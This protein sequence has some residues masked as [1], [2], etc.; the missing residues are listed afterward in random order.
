MLR[1]GAHVG[2]PGDLK[3]VKTGEW[4]RVEQDGTA[5]VGLSDR[6]QASLGDVV[7]VDL[8]KVGDSVQAASSSAVVESAKGAQDVYAPVSGGVTAVNDVLADAPEAIN[9]DPYGEGWIFKLTLS[10]KSELD[11]LLSPEDYAKAVES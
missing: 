7:Y 5:T 10:D 3:F 8:P 4:V 2:D 1:R 6:A 9:E 11:Q